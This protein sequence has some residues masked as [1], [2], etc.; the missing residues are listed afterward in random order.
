VE[1]VNTVRVGAKSP[2]S[3]FVTLTPGQSGLNMTS[4]TSCSLRVTRPDGSETTWEATLSEATQYEVT[5][6][7]TFDSLGEE[8]VLPGSYVLEPIIM[9]GVERRCSVF[10]MHVVPYP[11]P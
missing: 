7:H 11:T 10:K 1:A 3:V 6:T 9:A 2:E 5:A 4:V 8:T